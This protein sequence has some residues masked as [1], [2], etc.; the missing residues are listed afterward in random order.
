MLR[1][2][3]YLFLHIKIA[4]NPEASSIEPPLAVRGMT[5]LNRFV[6]QFFTTLFRLLH[7]SQVDLET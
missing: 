5:V 4:M 3:R 2:I 7:V 1:Q 6:L